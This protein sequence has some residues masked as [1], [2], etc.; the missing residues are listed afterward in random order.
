MRVLRVLGE[1]PGLNLA[2]PDEGVE[3]GLVERSRDRDRPEREGD[4]VHGDEVY[5]HHQLAHLVVVTDDVPPPGRARVVSPLDEV[6]Q[7]PSEAL[8]LLLDE[9]LLRLA[10]L[11]L[12]KIQ[13]LLL[14]PLTHPVVAE[15]DGH[16]IVDLPEEVVEGPAV[17]QDV[18]VEV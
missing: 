16:V 13:M 18:C 6:D 15:V 7:P 5:L 8:S 1:S 10:I 17:V 2:P 11:H 12:V 14:D 3:L 4:R 9:L